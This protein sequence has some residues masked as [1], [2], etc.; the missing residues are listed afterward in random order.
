M[1]LTSP[2]SRFLL[3]SARVKQWN[4]LTASADFQHALDHALLE[5]LHRHRTG[6]VYDAQAA[7]HKLDGAQEFARLLCSLGEVA[8][9]LK[10]TTDTPLDYKPTA[11]AAH[12]KPHGSTESFPSPIESL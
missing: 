5:M 2:K 4:E 7:A 6:P 3:D 9:P 8:E 11:V 10:R 12:L 1:P